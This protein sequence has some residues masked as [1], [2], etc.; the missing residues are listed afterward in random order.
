MAKEREIFLF[1]T[2]N[3]YWAEENEKSCKISDAPVTDDEF[4]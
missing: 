3:E 2:E 1:G 4:L